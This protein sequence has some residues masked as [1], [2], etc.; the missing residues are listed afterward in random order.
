MLWKKKY[1]IQAV[2]VSNLT[3]IFVVSLEHH[4]KANKVISWEQAWLILNV[5]FNK[6]KAW[7][8]L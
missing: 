1:Y 3:N 4:Y 8:D 2:K 7:F 6:P 5:F